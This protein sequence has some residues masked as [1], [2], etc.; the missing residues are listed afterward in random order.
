MALLKIR[1][2]ECLRLIRRQS[3]KP[4]D[5]ILAIQSFNTIETKSTGGI[6]YWGK[7]KQKL[8]SDEWLLPKLAE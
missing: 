6:Q 5:E 3:D 2:V 8:T 7:T 1:F 4:F